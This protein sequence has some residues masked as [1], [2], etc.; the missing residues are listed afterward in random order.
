MKLTLL[1]Y[2]LTISLIGCL[3]QSPRAFITHGKDK[4]KTQWYDGKIPYPYDTSKYYWRQYIKYQHLWDAATKK[5]DNHPSEK[6][7]KEMMRYQDS[8]VRYYKLLN[9]NEK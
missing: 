2:L 1:T 8:C 4:I 6:L 7:L 9:K 3:A 5:F